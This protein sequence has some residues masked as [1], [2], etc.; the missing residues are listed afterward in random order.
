MAEHA[1]ITYAYYMIQHE[2]SHHTDFPQMSI[3]GA[4]YG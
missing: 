2:G 4:D 1:K 3:S